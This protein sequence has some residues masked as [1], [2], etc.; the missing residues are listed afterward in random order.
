MF[1]RVKDPRNQ[2]Y[3][4]Y[5]SRVML[6]TMYYKSIAGISSMQEMTRTFSDEKICRNLYRFMGEDVKD[7]LPHG[8]TENEFLERLDP[9]EL[10]N[11]QHNIVYSMIRGKTFDNARVL[12]K[13]QVIVDATEL[14]EGYQKKN[15]HY[16]S[17]CYNRGSDNEYVKYHRSILEAK[18]YFGENLVRSIASET[19]ENSEEY[20]NQSDEAVKQNCESKA[21]V[22]LAAK[23]KQKFPRLPIIITTDGLYVTKTVLQICKDYHWDYI[24]RYKEGCASSIA[25]EYWALPEKETAGTD[26]EY[27]NKVM[28]NDF[29]VN[30]IYYRERRIVNGEEKE[31]EFAWIISIE[32]TKSNA[33]SIVRVGRNRW[34]IENQGFNRQKHWQGNIEHACSWNERAQKNHYLIEQIADFMKQL[35]E[36]FYLEKNEIK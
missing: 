7:Y 31:R 3:I 12:K 1:D 21:F 18:I 10:E 35:Y 33:K 26:I 25:R 11:V 32:I 36:Y 5:S 17:R 14:D 22:R 13:W 19:I 2:S 23:I 6:G 28:F 20:I 16:L 27:Q 34:K 15:E 8:V 30:L 24:I 4:D 29:D 9:R